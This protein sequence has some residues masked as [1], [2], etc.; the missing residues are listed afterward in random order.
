MEKQIESSDNKKSDTGDAFFSEQKA[1]VIPVIE[2]V[3]KVDKEVIETGRIHIRKEVTKEDIRMEIP[4]IN[5][6]YAVE[7]IPVKNQ[8]FD[9]PPTIR[10]EGDTMIIPVIKEVAEVIIRYEVTEEI[11]VTKNKAF[12]PKTQQVTLKKEKVIIE[13]EAPQK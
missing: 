9:Q 13:R 5:E 3:L 1:N 2:E 10:N 4:V 8:I 6:S 7:K 12:T 11:H